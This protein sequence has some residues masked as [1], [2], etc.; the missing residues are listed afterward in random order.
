ML[1]KASLDEQETLFCG[2]NFIFQQDN[3]PIHTVKATHEYLHGMGID[4]LFWTARSPD[5]NSIENAWGWL[6][7]AV[8]KDATQYNTLNELKT[9]ICN[10]WDDMPEGYLQHIIPSVKDRIFEGINRNV[11]HTSY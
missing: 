1:D 9:V 10:A 6:S 11:G 8:Y 2:N 3:A 5:L 4:V 7:H